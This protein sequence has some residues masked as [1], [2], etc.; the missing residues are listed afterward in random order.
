MISALTLS[1]ALGPVLTSL[2]KAL[3]LLTKLSTL[4]WEVYICKLTFSWAS[5]SKLS[6]ACCTLGANLAILAFDALSSLI[7][8]T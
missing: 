7:Y 1:S 8:V 4:D 3:I 6:L 5:L 2:Y